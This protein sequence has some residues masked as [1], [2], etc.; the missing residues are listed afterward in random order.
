VQDRSEHV[1]GQLPD[2]TDRQH[3]GGTKVPLVPSAGSTWWH[4]AAVA[5][6]RSMCP[7]SCCCTSWSIPGQGLGV[8]EAIYGGF[9]RGHA[10]LQPVEP[11]AQVDRYLRG[12]PGPRP[13]RS[14]S[15]APAPSWELIRSAL[16]GRGAAA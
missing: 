12:D 4:H 14:G 9:L 3:G 7:R 11:V 2:A 8:A 5:F 13:R 10:H 15:G 16:H 1:P 6:I